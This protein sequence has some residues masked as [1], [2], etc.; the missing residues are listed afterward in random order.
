MGGQNI[1]RC[2]KAAYKQNLLLVSWWEQLGKEY[3]RKHIKIS[4]VGFIVFYRQCW[5]DSRW[6]AV[7]GLVTDRPSEIQSDSWLELLVKMLWCVRAVSHWRL[8]LRLGCHATACL[9][10][11]YRWE[12]VLHSKCRQAD[13]WQLRP[14]SPLEPSPLVCNSLYHSGLGGFCWG[15]EH[16]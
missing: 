7:R 11:L 4:A 5:F 15:G 12:D 6:V 3:Y 13:T 9:C 14:A 8:S 2:C 1:Q 10:L 16:T